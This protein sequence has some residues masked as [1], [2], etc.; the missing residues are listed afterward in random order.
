MAAILFHSQ[1]SRTPRVYDV[2]LSI[3][4]IQCG[5]FGHSALS[6]N[7]S[8]SRSLEKSWRAQKSKASPFL[9]GTTALK[10]RGHIS[11]LLTFPE[12]HVLIDQV[13][14]DSQMVNPKREARSP[15]RGLSTPSVSEM[16]V[17]PPQAFSLVAKDNSLVLKS[18]L[19]S[20][21]QE[22]EAKN[23]WLD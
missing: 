4:G 9:L 8:L 22:Q 19:S 3:S 15:H 17:G 13:T 7:K 1:H 16:G 6:V 20:C 18:R 21:K 12:P 5:G 11:L 2:T 23:D 14:Q 10:G